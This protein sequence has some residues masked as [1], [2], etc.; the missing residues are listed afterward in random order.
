MSTNELNIALKESVKDEVM[1]AHF[2]RIWPVIESIL[3]AFTNATGLPMFIFIND[4]NIY[5]SPIEN[6]PDFCAGMLGS[7]ARRLCVENA[8]YRARGFEPEFVEGYHLC[9]AGMANGR[10]QIYVDGIGT[11]T[12]LYGSRKAGTPESLDR[13]ER[14]LASLS[15]DHPT[16]HQQLVR[17]NGETED[18]DEM[19]AEHDTELMGRILDVIKQLLEATI[20]FQANASNMAHELTVMMLGMFWEAKKFGSLFRTFEQLQQKTGVVSEMEEIATNIMIECQLGLYI[21]RNF[22]SHNSEKTY[23][24]IVRPQFAPVDLRRLLDEVI[25]LHNR[26]AEQKSIQIETEGLE[27]LPVIRGSYMELSRLFHNILNNAIKYSFHSIST[28]RR[29]IRVRSKVPYDPGFQERRFA[30]SFEN[31]GLGVEPDDIKK[32][33]DPGFRGRQAREEVMTGAGIG[34]SEALK[35]VQAHGGRIKFKSAEKHKDSEGKPVYLTTVEVILPYRNPMRK[36]S[37]SR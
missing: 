37:T 2:L 6:M 22:L 7:E 15:I 32:V 13:R 14:L 1:I 20:G 27:D 11:M 23:R 28:K 30:V 3:R 25:H 16:L 29:V 24:Q 19:I 36:S 21:V 26:Q 34:L 31:Y 35:I 10:R 9:H 8:A 17:L 33:F 18:Y 4:I 12:I 5:H